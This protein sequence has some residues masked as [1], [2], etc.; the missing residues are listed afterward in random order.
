VFRI[1]ERLVREGSLAQGDHD[2]LQCRDRPYFREH[3][4]DSR[5]AIADRLVRAAEG[6]GEVAMALA[7]RDGELDAV[8]VRHVDV[9]DHRVVAIGRYRRERLGSRARH[10]DDV[11]HASQRAR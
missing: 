10:G 4:A 8:D 2:L 6:D 7:Q 1:E 11:P 3:R 5:R 9:G